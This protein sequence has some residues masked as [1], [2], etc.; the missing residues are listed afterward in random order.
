MKTTT[1]IAVL[2]LGGILA[3]ASC[4]KDQGNNDPEPLPNN[5]PNTPATMPSLTGTW[6]A[7]G[8]NMAKEDQGSFAYCLLTIDANQNATWT[9]KHASIPAYDISMTG[10]VTIETSGSKDANG[11]PID[12]IWFA[13]SK[14]NGQDLS[15][16]TFGIYQI[17]DKTLTLDWMF[18]KNGEQYPD[19]SKGFGSGRSGVNSV[20]KYNLQ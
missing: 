1:F 6:K 7:T 13:F 14:I 20:S 17:I 18:M 10:K 9:K 16:T 8:T 2:F 3:C 11:K 15:G 4:K 5:T 12:R 19:P